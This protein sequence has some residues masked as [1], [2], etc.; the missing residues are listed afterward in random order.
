MR[1]TNFSIIVFF[2]FSMTFHCSDEKEESGLIPKLDVEGIWKI[3][4]SDTKEKFD[5]N[6]KQGYVVSYLEETE[7]TVEYRVIDDGDGIRI[8]RMEDTSPKGYFLF[9][10]RKKLSWTGIW[11]DELVRLIRIH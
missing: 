9:N 5:F 4:P 10:D 3:S 7:E 8:Q 11:N 2:L 6:R 1:I